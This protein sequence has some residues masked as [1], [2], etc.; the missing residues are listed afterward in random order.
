MQVI[1]LINMKGGVAKTTLAVNL[2]DVLNR[3]HGKKVALIDVD[4]Q[5]NA[6][7]CLM[8][9][10]KYTEHLKSSLN[11]V[12]DIFESPPVVT[13]ST[14]DGKSSNKEKSLKDIKLVEIRNDFSLLPGNL[15]LY[16]VE[17]KSSEGES[18]D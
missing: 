18:L 3:F 13:V 15:E 10:K 5:F 9:P 6:T 1:S 17:M 11:T 4:P 14:V 2:A 12:L 16:R 7:Q 8:D